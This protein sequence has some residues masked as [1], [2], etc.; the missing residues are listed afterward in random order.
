MP[1]QQINLGPAAA[2]L[3][4]ARA[5]DL[6]VGR[7]HLGPV[8]LV[9]QRE[10]AGERGRERCIGAKSER[11]RER[12]THTDRQNTERERER[13]SDRE[14]ERHTLTPAAATLHSSVSA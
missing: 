13:Q 10:R 5:D 6:L 8:A 9:R 12:Q 14:T 7:V 11:A 2:T 4:A 3:T 1:L